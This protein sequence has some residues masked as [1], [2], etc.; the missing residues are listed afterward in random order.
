MTVNRKIIQALNFLKIPVRESFYDGDDAEYITFETPFSNGADYGDDEP[1]EVITEVKIHWWLPM[2][3]NYLT[4]KNRIRKALFYAE[5][6]F[7]TLEVIPDPDSSIRHILFECE[8]EEE[9]N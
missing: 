4:D 6:T 2:K 9:E 7:P 3:K 8:I 5:F 1:E